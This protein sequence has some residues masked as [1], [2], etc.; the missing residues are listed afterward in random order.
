ME[1]EMKSFLGHLA[2][3]IYGLKN[4]VLNSLPAITHIPENYYAYSSYAYACAYVKVW[5]SLYFDH[6]TA[7]KA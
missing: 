3:C 5:T 7:E 6:P 2:T 4:Y 1:R